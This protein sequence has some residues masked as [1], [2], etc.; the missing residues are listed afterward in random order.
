MT[1]TVVKVVAT[2]MVPLREAAVV[3]PVAAVVALCVPATIAARS[4]AIDVAAGVR[5]RTTIGAATVVTTTHYGRMTTKATTRHCTGMPAAVAAMPAAV[6]AAATTGCVS[7]TAAAVA[8]ATAATT[9]AAAV[10]DERHH[11]TGGLCRQ[12]CRRG[13]CGCPYECRHCQAARQGS[14]YCKFCSHQMSPFQR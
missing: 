4:G 8:A 11:P 7:T 10:A 6:A 3:E 9:T 12:R 14:R 1:T 5:S 13:L 2:I